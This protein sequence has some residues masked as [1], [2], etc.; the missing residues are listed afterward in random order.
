MSTTK[1]Y[2]ENIKTKY[3]DFL[4]KECFRNQEGQNNDVLIVNK[5][6]VFRFPKYEKGIHEL[7]KET[8]FLIKIQNHI[9]LRIPNPTYINLN[10]EEVGQAFVGYRLIKG[11]MLK[12]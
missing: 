6:L 10:N 1:L 8:V 3:P 5:E 4:I 12:K 9:S 11:Q 7:Q 2:I